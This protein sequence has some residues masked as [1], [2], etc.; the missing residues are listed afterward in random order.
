MGH[1]LSQDTLLPVS[2]LFLKNTLFLKSRFSEF[3]FLDTKFISISKI[4]LLVVAPIVG[5][6]KVIELI[7]EVTGCQ[8]CI[9]DERLGSASA[10]VSP[11]V[12]SSVLS[13]FL[14]MVLVSRRPTVP[15]PSL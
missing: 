12:Q 4:L 10:T 3:C 7:F 5:Y 15:S 6:E 13:I 8:E 1:L 14:Y 11:P 2:D 9:V